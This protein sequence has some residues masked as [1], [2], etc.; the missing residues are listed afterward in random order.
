[1]KLQ[2]NFLK[3]TSSCLISQK[4]FFWFL[5]SYDEMIPICCLFQ[6]DISGPSPNHLHF[7]ITST[8]KPSYHI[9]KQHHRITSSTTPSY[10]IIYNTVVTLLMINKSQLTNL[11]LTLWWINLRMWWQKMLSSVVVICYSWKWI[12][13]RWWW[14]RW[15]KKQCWTAL[16]RVVLAVTVVVHHH[17][18]EEAITLPQATLQITT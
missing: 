18:L 6:R 8:T 16:A 15:K 4:K 11:R 12:W 13:R 9:I 2:I 1:M 5:L 7:I 14:R 17:H 3:L 10:H